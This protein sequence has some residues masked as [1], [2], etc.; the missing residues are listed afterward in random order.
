MQQA[1]PIC[2]AEHINE[3]DAFTIQTEP[4]VSIDLMERAALKCSQWLMRYYSLKTILLI[5]KSSE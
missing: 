3:I 2:S 4:I 1:L 5:K